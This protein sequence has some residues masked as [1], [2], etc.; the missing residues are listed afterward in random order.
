MSNT[1]VNEISEREKDAQAR[2]SAQ[3]D[4]GHPIILQAG[5]GTGKTAALVARILMWCMGPGWE[6]NQASLSM[7]NAPAE[8]VAGRTI[9]RLVAITF[10]DKA[11]AEMAGRVVQGLVCLCN[12]DE[13]IGFD[14]T[15]LEQSSDEIA[16][17]A[18][19][20]LGV[21]DRLRVSTIHS[22]CQQVVARGALELGIHPNFQVDADQSL[23]T[24]I[25]DDVLGTWWRDALGER[26][27]PDACFLLK[28]G[29]GPAEIAD[30][31]KAFLGANATADEVRE[32][33][34][35]CQRMGDFLTPLLATIGT[36]VEHVAQPVADATFTGRALRG[37]VGLRCICA[38]QGALAEVTTIEELMDLVG[39]DDFDP[40]AL[41]NDLHDK[42][43][44]VKGIEKVV[45]GTLDRHRKY[46][47]PVKVMLN[48]LKT[49][50]P[51]FLR[52]A[53]R[54][55]APLLD[56]VWQ[57]LRR[58]GV[59]NF[60]D[61]LRLAKELVCKNEPARQ[62]LCSGIDQLL[63]DEV[64]DT[65]PL[66]FEIVKALSGGDAAEAPG[67][68][69]VGDPKQSI[70]GW[71]Q[72][73]L[74]AYEEFLHYLESNGGVRHSLSI[75]FRS[76]P[77]VLDAVTSSVQPVM[78]EKAGF[79]PCFEE[80]L[81]CDSK[82]GNPGFCR[83]ERRPVEHWVTV[84]RDSLR[85]TSPSKRTS[86]PRTRGIEAHAVAKDIRE[87]HAQ[88][89]C[90][91]SEF[92]I[93]TQ[94]ATKRDQLLGALRAA[95]IPYVVAG[96]RSFN[97][98]REV[99]DALNIV[100]AV[101]EP[102]DGVALLGALR[103]SV[104]GL[105]DAAVAGLWAANLPEF[106][107]RTHTFGDE[108]GAALDEILEA[109]RARTPSVEEAYQGWTKTVRAFVRSVVELRTSW[110]TEAADRFL[111][112]LRALL[113]LDGLEASRFLGAHRL[114]NL[115]Q[116][117]DRFLEAAMES[118]S[119]ASATLR[120][121][122][123]AIIQGDEEEEATPGGESID[124]VRVMTIHK[125]KGLSFGQLYVLGIDRNMKMEHPSGL[126]ALRSPTGQLEWELSRCGSIGFPHLKH[127]AQ[128]VRDA[129]DVRLWYVALTRAE[130]RLVTVGAN[131]VVNPE[132]LKS[133]SDFL[134]MGLN[135][136]PDLARLM[137]RRS[138]EDMDEAPD[139]D[140]IEETVEETVEP[141]DWDESEDEFEP[142]PEPEVALQSNVMDCNGVRWMAVD[143]KNLESDA[144]GERSLA[145]LQME[146]DRVLEF[147][148]QLSA[149]REKAEVRSN[150]RLI[151]APSSLKAESADASDEV[152]SGEGLGES[153]A[154][155]VG[156]ALH[157]AL[158]VGTPEPDFEA[159]ARFLQGTLVS[160][161]LTRAEAAFVETQ[162]QLE[163]G[164]LLQR[165]AAIEPKILGR[166]VSLILKA[167]ETSDGPVGAF[168][169][170]IDLLYV[171]PGDGCLVVA[172][173]KTDRVP[174]SSLH[175]QAARH[176][177]QG[178]LY[179]R[180]VRAALP[181][182]DACRFELWFLNHDRIV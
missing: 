137:D 169:G 11:A 93:L 34:Y 41:L 87:I 61:L 106:V 156:H 179:T 182:F 126:E 45:A 89:E 174:E 24:E 91:W 85:D 42:K 47:P 122:R 100:T 113:P 46:F 178:E 148:R 172:D 28:H 143:Y 49:V 37:V 31:L 30:L 36:Y 63:L 88:G 59:L 127:R 10:T 177:A 138:M 117:F 65:D 96:D 121:V 173:F 66:Q 118:R 39:G 94:T 14:T 74:R 43:V 38:L 134:Q 123:S 164:D 67:L 112:R 16:R 104:V 141:P 62:R 26:Q 70:Y 108:A 154:K 159:G 99:M 48:F 151:G 90:N 55:A 71:R 110:R 128:M 79:Q 130:K 95:G 9:D 64:Q 114:A 111:S 115:N 133:F 58:E 17:R 19:A 109:A 86:A 78:A 5:A 7:P 136:V 22:F 1:N 12:G 27:D 68:F 157:L 139:E 84:S 146:V 153:V 72:A 147:N 82:R 81:V 162:K 15:R 57:R 155:A 21:I 180:A 129:E 160:A 13:V 171:D 135:G 73:D 18:K 40:S 33:P 132:K 152:A 144:R 142:N 80:L 69:I 52:A 4:F 44:G 97:K 102:M 56:D 103:S 149:E 105:P 101:L 53:S 20:L 51:E 150:R 50:D 83:G 124:A 167:D 75:N 29:I 145:P 140:L 60:N 163:G 3:C 32:D 107:S 131:S 166:E 76:V 165:L 158:E 170:F 35:A 25:V 176:A 77:A 6:K 92:G 119:S 8:S 23:T 161:E 125:A 2:L 98:R 175:E 116:F 168:S 54:V 120:S 181:D